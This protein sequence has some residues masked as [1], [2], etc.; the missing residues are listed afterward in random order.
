MPVCTLVLGL[1]TLSD[2]PRSGQQLPSAFCA[3]RGRQLGS[4]P[5]LDTPA[6]A[7][8]EPV[9]LGGQPACNTASAVSCCWLQAQREAWEEEERRRKFKASTRTLQNIYGTKVDDAY[10]CC[11]EG[12][13]GCLSTPTHAFQQPPHELAATPATSLKSMV[14]T[15]PHRLP[16]AR[17][18]MGSCGRYVRAAHVATA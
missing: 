10:P 3:D 8:K 13:H 4:S 2:I 12:L 11:M 6:A 15:G 14:L 18:V 17:N 5:C 16:V 7:A 1:M 9:Q